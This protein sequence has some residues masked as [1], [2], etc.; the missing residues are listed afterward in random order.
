MENKSHAFWAG[1]FTLGLLAIVVLVLAWF[2]HD[3]AVRVP[4]DLVAKASVT[5]LNPDSIVRYRGIP[6]G[7][8]RSIQ[9]DPKNP[10]VIMVRIAV[11]P[12]TPMTHSTFA[13]LGYQ[14]VTGLGFVQLDDTGADPTPLP[15]SESK[16]AQLSLQPG[17]LDIMQKRGEAMIK[18]MEQVTVSLNQLVGE[19]TRQQLLQT[20]RSIQ[21]AADNIA[22]LA[23]NAN[24]VVARLPQTIGKLDRTL[25]SVHALAFN[26]NNPN[27]PLMSNLNKV[28]EA[29]NKAGT[30][31]TQ[32]SDSMQAI[33]ASLN[34]ETL[35]RV[36]SLSDDIRA[37]TQSFNRAADQLSSNPRG[38]L[39]GQP[40]PKPGPGEAGFAWP[41]AT[42]GK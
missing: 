27:G 24:P 42:D 19:Q 2:N 26:L 5:G 12:D 18:Q 31:V 6:V 29:A 36:S 3:R 23:K 28:G 40:T 37:A 7:K 10:G 14:G 39:F 15:S 41:A 25:D 13:T 20:S 34:Y 8:V 32:L 11:N 4:Y 22:L 21:H 33:T 9:F 38:L 1:A 17:L 35:P 30:A 16:V